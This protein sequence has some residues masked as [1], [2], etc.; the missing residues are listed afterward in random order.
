[1]YSF[2]SSMESLTLIFSA[3]SSIFLTWRV[4]KTPHAMAEMEHAKIK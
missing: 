4:L 3:S 1:M 2:C